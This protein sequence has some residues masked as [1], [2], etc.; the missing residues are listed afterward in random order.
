[1]SSACGGFDHSRDGKLRGKKTSG[2]DGE[3]LPVSAA[4]VALVFVERSGERGRALALGPRSRHDVGELSTRLV[5]ED[6][7]LPAVRHLLLLD[8]DL[9]VEQAPLAGDRL[10]PST[11]PHLELD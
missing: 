3:V 11:T 5:P 7:L 10:D 6:Q 9:P 8:D 2:A 1:V 4:G